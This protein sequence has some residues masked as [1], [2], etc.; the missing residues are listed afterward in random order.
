MDSKD[1][2]IIFPTI[3]ESTNTMFLIASGL[4]KQ[5]HRVIVVSIPGYNDIDNFM[6]GFDMFTAKMQIFDAHL[7]GAGFGGF[8]AL[9]LCSC[10]QLSTRIRSLVVICS[11]M[12][13]DTFKKRGG[14][15]TSSK[16]LITDEL[17]I[18]A[19]P[20]HLQ[21]TAEFVLS[22][23][24]AMSSTLATARVNMRATALRAPIPE[25]PPNTILIIQCLDWS[26][27]LK[28]DGVPHAVIK[29]QKVALLK[30]G[31]NWPHIAAPEKLMTYVGL[32]LSKMRL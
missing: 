11:Y 4:I 21:Q 5:G 8:L 2:V 9:H 20:L 16:S 23:A 10:G 28:D 32:H 18:E 1:A 25:M 14:F 6:I 27:R 30:T 12:T 29:N 13:T 24:D 22:D 15:F 3:A 26:F 7:I 19:I 17:P 31:G